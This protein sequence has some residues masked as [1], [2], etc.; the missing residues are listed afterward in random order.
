MTVE[1]IAY[2]RKPR[3]EITDADGAMA[4]LGQRV[5]EQYPGA[6]TTPA[7]VRAIRESWAKPTLWHRLVVRV[8]V[9]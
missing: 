4:D 5:K 1:P 7:Q 6:A 3:I 8:T 2:R 9:R